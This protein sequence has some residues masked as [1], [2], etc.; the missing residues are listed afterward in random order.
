MAKLIDA[1]ALKATVSS[2]KAFAEN[3]KNIPCKTG[4][5]VSLEAIERKMDD[6]PD[7]SEPLRARIKELEASQPSEEDRAVLWLM[8]EKG[9]WIGYDAHFKMWFDTENGCTPYSP[10]NPVDE[11]KKLGWGG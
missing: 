1:D 3:V 2:L 8:K 11:A 9:M 6:Q 4:Q 7:A 10:L 5:L